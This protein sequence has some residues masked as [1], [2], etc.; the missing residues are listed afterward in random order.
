VIFSEYH[1]AGSNTAGFMVRKGRWK[2][3]YYVRFQP[4]LFDLMSDPEELVDLASDLTHAQVVRDMEAELRRI[5]DPEAVDAQAKHDQLA[6][7]ERLGG[8]EAAANMGA[9]GATPAP[10]AV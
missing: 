10:S 4:E 5:C 2:F 1:A 9:S 8:P 3:H 7:I 6:M